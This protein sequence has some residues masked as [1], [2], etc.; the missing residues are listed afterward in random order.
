M[1]LSSDISLVN[2]VFASPADCSSDEKDVVFV[3]D[4]SRKPY[5]R[6]SWS[7]LLQFVRDVADRLRVTNGS[8]RV[9]VVRYA[10]TA[11]LSIALNDS[12]RT[13]RLIANLDYD[14]HDV[15]DLAG[16]LDVTRS[17]VFNDLRLGARSV[18]VVVT[19]HLLASARLTAAVDRLRSSFD[20]VELIVV[21]VTG[22]G[23][24]EVDTLSKIAGSE[25]SR[26]DDFDKLSDKMDE[27]V[28]FICD[29]RHELR[30]PQ[31]KSRSTRSTAYMLQ[32]RLFS[33]LLCVRLSVQV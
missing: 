13:L 24:V 28:Q 10:D 12:S 14:G 6:Q 20:D 26:I 1:T 17:Q 32:L 16:A 5:G 11:E 25:T 3:V 15:S 4:A 33:R 18:V 29:G 21:A 23:G 7:K 22:H 2:C 9:A 30:T 19:E 8:V 31:G 27:V